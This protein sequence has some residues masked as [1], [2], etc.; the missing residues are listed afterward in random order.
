M[1]KRNLNTFVKI[2][3]RKRAIRIQRAVRGFL[4]RRELQR[5]RKAFENRLA[6][7]VRFGLLWL[8]L[9]LG[10]E[11]SDLRV[12]VVAQYRAP[13]VFFF[14]GT[15]TCKHTIVSRVQYFHPHHGIALFDSSF[16]D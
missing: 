6:R 8:L 5:R 14:H 4:A 12:G 9:R 3:K 2:G 16:L 15:Q 13:K 1:L 7:S 10:K 11:D